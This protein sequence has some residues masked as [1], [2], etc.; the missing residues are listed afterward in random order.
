MP[1]KDIIECS[2]AAEKVG[3]SFISVAESFYRDG[4]ALASAIA[5]N[6]FRIKFGTSVMPIYTRSP[7]QLAMGTA[8]FQEL[9]YGRLA[10]LGLGLGYRSRTEQYFGVRQLH[11]AERMKEYVEI[12]RRLLSG[13]NVS[14][15]GRFFCFENFPKLLSQPL[16]IPIYFGS[17]GPQML[18]LAGQ[19][20]DGAI[21][22]SISTHEYVRFA[23]ERIE[24]GAKSVG[25]DPSK[26]E[27]GHSII[28]ACSD[29]AQEAVNAAKEDILFYVSYPELDPVMEKSP[30]KGE[31]LRMRKL[32]VGGRKAEALAMI[33]DE[34][35]DAFSVYGT[36]K[37]CKA[38]L[39]RFLRRGITLPIIRVSVTPYK[40]IERKNVFLKAIHSLLK[41]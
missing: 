40:E 30:F 4:F 24:E 37:E 34:M 20:A 38:R 8:T 31:A 3:F 6:T 11:R 35:L 19:I 7:F 29:D 12:V 36:P 16:N 5:S 32:Y 23:I 9:S 28:Y 25:R 2:K 1:I 26:I 41:R 18:A 22:N 15:H 10:F 21:L 14:Y 17:S 13:G 33:T 27:I 39:E